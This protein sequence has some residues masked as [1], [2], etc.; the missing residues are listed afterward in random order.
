M[1]KKD[2]YDICWRGKEVKGMVWKMEERR[3]EKRKQVR[4]KDEERAIRMG[5]NGK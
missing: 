4:T 5:K 2:E 1:D 3:R